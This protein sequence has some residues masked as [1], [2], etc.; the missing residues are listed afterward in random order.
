MNCYRYILYI[1]E[2]PQQQRRYH[3]VSMIS[4]S[5]TFVPCASWSWRD[6]SM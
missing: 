5:Y 1:S 3:I 2:F 6:W 4:R